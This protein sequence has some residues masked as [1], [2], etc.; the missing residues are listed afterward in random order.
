L[1]TAPT[2]ARFDPQFAHARVG[3]LPPDLQVLSMDSSE[4]SY[5]A[6]YQY[7]P[8]PGTNTD[9]PVVNLRL[10]QAGYEQSQHPGSHEWP[11]TPAPPVNG[12]PAVWVHP[13]GQNGTAAVLRWSFA[14][15][16][17]ATVSVDQLR[18]GLD[19]QQTAHRVADSVEIGTFERI[20]TPFQLTRIPAGATLS[21]VWVQ[22][23]D[24]ASMPW[25]AN[26]SLSSGD[27][28]IDVHV[29]AKPDCVCG[30]KFDTAQNTTVNGIP[31]W[32]AEGGVTLYYGAV[33]A[34]VNVVPAL[35]PT[36]Q[37]DDSRRAIQA[38]LGSLSLTDMAAAL[39]V[40]PN[41]AD[42]RAPLVR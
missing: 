29:F 20:A 40:Y 37:A 26:L 35:R 12:H 14:A 9:G 3:W 19:A 24:D 11:T 25:E 42:W 8:A 33:I 22:I 10:A 21:S 34:E 1:T 5:G 28:S 23:Q 15:D 36:T 2:P 7:K 31:A 18:G 32:L 17:S 27:A 38:A 4:L 41:H 13:P 30:G 16:A 6:A 39:S